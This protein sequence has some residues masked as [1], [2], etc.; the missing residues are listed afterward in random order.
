M[1]KYLWKDMS[2]LFQ[3]KYEKRSRAK[4]VK[5]LGIQAN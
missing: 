1:K 5:M 4:V 3:K 2:K